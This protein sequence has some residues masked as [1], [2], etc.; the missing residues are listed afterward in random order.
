MADD[1]SAP[2]GPRRRAPKEASRGFSMKPTEFPIARLAFGVAAII[3]I[4]VGARAL[5]IADPMG[6]RPVAEIDVAGQRHSESSRPVIWR[7][8]SSRLERRRIER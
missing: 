8:T 5:L 1:L 7:K 3:M 2:L 6:G 4:G